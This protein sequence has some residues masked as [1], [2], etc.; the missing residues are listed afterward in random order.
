MKTTLKV[1]R[2]VQF[3]MLLTIELILGFTPIG[4]IMIPPVAIT[5]LHIPVI[6]CGIVMGPL[7]GGGLGLVFG[8]ISMLK[9]VT[10]AVSPIDLLFNPVASGNALASVVMCLVPRILLGVFSALLF[11]GFQK[12]FKKRL[13]ATG[14]S[15]VLATVLHTLMVL[16]CL[17][18]F[19]DQNFLLLVLGTILTLNGGL[20]IALA[21]LVALP[22]S[23]AL[24][25]HAAG[26]GEPAAR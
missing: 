18:L 7:F 1:R 11:K 4:L 12:L 21:A 20:E 25:K 24:L 26:E 10:A 9:A 8:L 2:M 5:L 14:F 13:L 16:G 17:F 15:A 19:F 6:I 3:S 23:T 22:V